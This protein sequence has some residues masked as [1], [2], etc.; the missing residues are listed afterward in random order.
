M[1]ADG[2]KRAAYDRYGHAGL[3]G[4]SGQSAGF[5]PTVFQ[6]FSD[7]FG[8]FFG[9]G[10]FGQADAAAAACSVAPICAKT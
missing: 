2:D 8:E 4:G 5:D 3:G 10:D 6:D 1:L 7:I 9:F